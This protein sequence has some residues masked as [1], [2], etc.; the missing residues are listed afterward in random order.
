MFS[1]LFHSHYFPSSGSSRL[2]VAMQ[3]TDGTSAV[4]V[5]HEGRAGVRAGEA[6]LGKGC[7]KTQVHTQ[8]FGEF[9]CRSD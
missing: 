2:T 9:L 6:S 7:G 4:W 3:V 5:R 1:G 8:E